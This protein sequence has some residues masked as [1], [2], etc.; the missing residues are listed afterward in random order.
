MDFFDVYYSYEFSHYML[1]TKGRGR[2]GVVGSVV[3]H[4]ISVHKGPR[5]ISSTKKKNSKRRQN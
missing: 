4:L 2:A 5:P 1:D 3:E